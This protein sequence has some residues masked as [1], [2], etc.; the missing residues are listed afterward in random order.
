MKNRLHMKNNKIFILL[1][2]GVGLRNFAF[3]NFHDLA[4]AKGFDVTFWNNTPFDLQQL[5]FTEKKITRSKSHPFTDLLKRSRAQIDLSQNIK[6][7]GDAV[8][9]TY[10]APL[11]YKDTKTTIKSLVVKSLLKIFNSDNGIVKIRK[12]IKSF[13]YSSSNDL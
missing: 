13:D 9:D 2:D 4:V 6:K 1:P 3:T 5:G 7:T 8:Y 10:R 12:K 11:S